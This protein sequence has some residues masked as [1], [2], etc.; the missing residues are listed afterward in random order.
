MSLSCGFCRKA[1]KRLRIMKEKH[2]EL[3]F[4]II[5]NGDKSKLD[6][7]FKDT[8]ATNIDYSMFNG[9]AQFSKLNGGT[10]LPTIKWVQDTT[11]IRESNY[12]TLNEQEILAWI[13]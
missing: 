1:A 8:K 5:L 7:F 4:Y 9:A 3:P 2:P 6:D 12:L 11:V 10:T 13:K